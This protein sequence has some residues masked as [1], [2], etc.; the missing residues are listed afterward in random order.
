LV[1]LTKN[2]VSHETES[3]HKYRP[4]FIHKW[5]PAPVS[6]PINWKKC[7]H[8]LNWAECNWLR[9][10]PPCEILNGK[11][12]TS[13]CFSMPNIKWY[14]LSIFFL[15]VIASLFSISFRFSFQYY[16]EWVACDF[17]ITLNNY[18]PS[19]MTHLQVRYKFPH[20][21]VLHEL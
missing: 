13:P 12:F 15:Y 19:N 7:M 9:L 20:I 8:P 2:R 11:P 21:G 4:V 10:S 18:I 14:W 5:V 6:L 3:D 16:K 1:L 17:Y